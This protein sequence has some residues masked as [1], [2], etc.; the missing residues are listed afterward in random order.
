MLVTF[1]PAN[2]NTGASVININALG[3]VAIVT[4]SGGAISASSIVAGSATT[5][6]YDGTSFRQQTGQAFSFTS[7]GVVIP[8]YTRRQHYDDFVINAPTTTTNGAALPGMLGWF[9]LIT[10]TAASVSGAGLVGID[11][12]N[13]A[14]GVWNALNGTTTTGV[15]GR[16]LSSIQPALGQLDLFFRVAFL[17]VPTSAQNTQFK[18]G[19]SDFASSTSPANQVSLIMLFNGSSAAWRGTCTASSVSSST[20]DATTPAII[21]QSSGALSFYKLQVSINAAWT[22]V[23]FFVNGTQIGSAITTNIPSGATLGLNPY[24]VAIKTAG[25]VGNSLFIDQYFDDYQYA[26]P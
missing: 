25:T 18:F 24:W 17:S 12:N 14:D 7:P 1:N 2:T 19:I 11:S 4:N 10:G 3:S 9:A 21:A 23:S 22:S 20:T 8:P 16:S 5:I 6:I 26:T 13:K 15:S